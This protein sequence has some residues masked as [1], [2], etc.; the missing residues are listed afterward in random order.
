MEV[1]PS[2]ADRGRSL[3]ELIHKASL[4]IPGVT[5]SLRELEIRTH[6]ADPSLNGVD[7]WIQVGTSHILIQDK[8]KESMSQP[9]VAQF[10]TCADRIRSRLPSEEPV[11]LMWASKHEPT[12]NAGKLLDEHSAVKV[13]CS[14]NIESLAR[15]VLLQIC[16]CLEVDCVESLRAIPSSKKAVAMGSS[17]HG[18]VA[19]AVPVLTYDDSEEGKADIA[20]MKRMI[21]T[22]H[23]TIRRVYTAISYDGNADLHAL[24]NATAPKTVEE[25]MNGKHSKVDYTAFLKAVRSICC[26]TSKKP[27]QSRSLFL[28]VKLRK[29]SVEL[30]TLCTPYESKRKSLLSKKS[31][32]GKTLAT[33]KATAEPI[34]EAEFK[35]SAAHCEDYWENRMNR[36]TGKIEK[37]PAN[38]I[39]HAFWTHQCMV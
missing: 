13:R 26:P 12:S 7:H 23:G 11:Y 24:W 22:I 36:V 5:R 34:T 25:W 20:E 32:W 28:Y 31:I 8:W 30:S 14:I 15:C 3:E 37:V 9:E 6:F 29:L 38:H 4:L 10:L 1:I 39:E 35:S 33:F 19:P 27:L 18:P 17:K 2:A 21:E 16:E